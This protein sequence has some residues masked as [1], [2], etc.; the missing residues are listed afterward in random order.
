MHQLKAVDD[1]AQGFTP[2]RWHR[3]YVSRKEG[4][5]RFANIEICVDAWMS[6]LEEYATKK[7]YLPQPVTAITTWEQREKMTN[8]KNRNEKRSNS[9][10]TSSNKFEDCTR[11]EDLNLAKKGKP[12]ERKWISFNKS[13]KQWKQKIDYTK[14]ILKYR[15]CGDRDETVT[16]VISEN[17]KQVQN[18]YKTRPDWV[19]KVIH[20]ELCKRLKFDHENEMHK[21]LWDFGIQTSYVIP[22]R[23]PDI[24]LIYKK[25]WTYEDHSIGFQTFFRMGTFIDSTHMKL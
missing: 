3:I 7:D 15:L 24:V 9:I 8:I 13:I 4:G 1:D 2:G 21:V 12:Q 5:R 23:R 22:T 10:Y 17:S 19:G 16:Y 11:E 20:M 25:K 18:V 14:Q 6:G